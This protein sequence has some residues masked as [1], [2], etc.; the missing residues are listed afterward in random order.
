MSNKSTYVSLFPEFSGLLWVVKPQH[1]C[2]SKQDYITCKMRNSPIGLWL[3]SNC[4]V[5]LAET[6]D[7]SLP[8][9]CANPLTKSRPR[10]TRFVLALGSASAPGLHEL[11]QL[12]LQVYTDCFSLSSRFTR[13]VSAWKICR[14]CSPWLIL[15][16]LPTGSPFTWHIAAM[17]WRITV[18][19]MLSIMQCSASIPGPDNT[20]NEN[21][22]YRSLLNLREWHLLQL[23]TSWRVRFIGNRTEQL[24]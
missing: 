3:L 19:S 24:Y 4:Q 8:R 20:A 11:F 14:L 1:V 10:F 17:G 18:P 22:G 7:N 6:L 12:Q 5:K 13:I 2:F 9:V 15:C 21:R 16:D 23:G